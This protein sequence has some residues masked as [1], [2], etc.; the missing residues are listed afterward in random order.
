[1]NFQEALKAM[2][3]GQKVRLPEWRGYWFMDK[4]EKV[5]AIT[6]DGNIEEAWVSQ[7]MTRDN[8]EIATGC[9]FGWAITA[10]K[11]GKLVTRKGWNGK[12]MFVFMRPAD[13][14]SPEMVVNKV[15][16]LPK[17]VKDYV[18][19]DGPLVPLA[20]RTDNIKFT[21]YLCMKNAQGEIM[22]GWAATQTDM[23]A[24]D[25]ELFEQ[26]SWLEAT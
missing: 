7:Y 16:S 6:K 12:G 15:K 2:R 5:F 17:A 3:K 23:L 8:F 26:I 25:W 13:E 11:A 18:H 1:M 14:L 9:D 10:L 21:P 4:N 22:N 24:E 19:N 20:D